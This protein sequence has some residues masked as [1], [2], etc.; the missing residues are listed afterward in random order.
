MGKDYGPTAKGSRVQ[1]ADVDATGASRA[2][3]D[4]LVRR[5]RELR[6]FTV[7]EH[8]RS[9]LVSERNTKPIPRTF[10]AVALDAVWD[11]LDEMFLPGAED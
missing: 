4:E 9:R 6:I 11:V 8:H 2:T 7:V 1:G 10:D 5:V 3:Y